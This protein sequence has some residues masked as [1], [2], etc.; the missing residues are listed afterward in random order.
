MYSWEVEGRGEGLLVNAPRGARRRPSP[1]PL[2]AYRER[3]TSSGVLRHLAP[4]YVRCSQ[5][6]ALTPFPTCASLPDMVGFTRHGFY[7][8]LIGSA[9]LLVVAVAL[10][11]AWWPLA[12]VVIPVLVWL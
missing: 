11:W 4:R 12:L 8:M 5:L 1:Y 2:P 10:G 3:G 7:E 6:L 9:A